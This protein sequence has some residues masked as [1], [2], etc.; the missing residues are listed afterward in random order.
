MTLGEFATLYS[1]LKAM[2]TK[3][4]S[5]GYTFQKASEFVLSWLVNAKA[6][7]VFH[8]ADFQF[9]HLLSKWM[10]VIDATKRK[11][12]AE[13]M[14]HDFFSDANV[15]SS[16]A[17]SRS[18]SDPGS[19]PSP[20]RSPERDRTN[21]DPAGVPSSTRRPAQGRTN[22]DPADSP[23]STSYVLPETSKLPEWA[24]SSVNTSHRVLSST[25]R[26]ASGQV[27]IATAA[28]QGF[29]T[30]SQKEYSMTGRGVIT[31]SQNGYPMTS[32]RRISNPTLL[33]NT[34][35]AGGKVTPQQPFF[36]SFVF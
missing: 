5:Q 21:S 32:S 20:V 2:H 4:E 26:G 31:V 19:I 13:C 18:K 36:G 6:P 9:Q 24:K 12:L 14:H 25:F 29:M 17:R 33:S 15:T 34:Y 23:L 7:P 28:D 22:S 11:Q 3:Y 8:C 30:A 35:L 1:P 27:S 10:L 16:P